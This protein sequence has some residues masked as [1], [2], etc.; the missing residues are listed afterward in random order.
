MH[1]RT[2]VV[3][4]LAVFAAG[5]IAGSVL[6]ANDPFSTNAMAQAVRHGVGGIMAFTGQID[7][8]QYGI[9][10]IDVDAGTMWV[11][12]MKRGQLK[13]LAARSWM[14]DRYLEEYN[15]ANPV[16]SEVARLIVGQEKKAGDSG[17]EKLEKGPARVVE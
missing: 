8:D 11:Y 7:R 14:Y 3:K 12:Q 5:I 4:L 13:L 9:I 6:Y 10:M 1:S 2:G 16:P 17:W 15:C